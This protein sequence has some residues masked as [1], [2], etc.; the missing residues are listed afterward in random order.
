M[1]ASGL[2]A[3]AARSMEIWALIMVS[4]LGASIETSRSNSAAADSTPSA[5]VRQNELFVILNITSTFLR[6]CRGSLTGPSL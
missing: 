6:S 5:T 3:V 4:S 1:M 2:P